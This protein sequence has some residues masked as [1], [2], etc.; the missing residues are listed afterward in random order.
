MTSST[1][2]TSTRL[3]AA[4]SAAL[5]AGVLTACGD[6]GGADGAPESI[7]LEYNLFSPTSVVLQEMG[8]AEEA[9][10]EEGIEVDWVFSQGSG[11]TLE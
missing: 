8:W 7:T 11:Q 1:A 6:G 9:F 2:T 4:G 5:F 3:F 10:E